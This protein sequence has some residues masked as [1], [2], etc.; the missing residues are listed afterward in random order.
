[1]MSVLGQSC[2]RDTGKLICS[3][4]VLCACP[5]VMAWRWTGEVCTQG[6]GLRARLH[7]CLNVMTKPLFRMF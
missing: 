4:P 6:L 1:M 2:D 5:G 7:I 3:C